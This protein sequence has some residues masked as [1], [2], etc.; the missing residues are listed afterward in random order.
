MIFQAAMPCSDRSKRRRDSQPAWASGCARI[1]NGAFCRRQ[2]AEEG[3]RGGQMGRNAPMGGHGLIRSR[4]TGGGTESDGCFP[5]FTPCRNAF[6]PAADSF[7]MEDPA[8]CSE[9]LPARSRA[10]RCR[11]GVRLRSPLPARRQPVGA[12]SRARMP[13]CPRERG[14]RRT[15]GTAQIPSRDRGQ[16]RQRNAHAGHRAGGSSLTPRR[17]HPEQNFR[18]PH[19]GSF[20]DNA[21]ATDKKRGVP[22][23]CVGA[24]LPVRRRPKAGGSG[25][26]ELFFLCRHGGGEA[27]TQRLERIAAFSLSA[28][29]RHTAWQ[30]RTAFQSPFLCPSGGARMSPVI[31]PH[32]PPRHLPAT[33]RSK[34]RGG[35]RRPSLRTH[36]LQAGEAEPRSGLLP[37]L[38]AV[39]A[40]LP[41]GRGS[42][43][44]RHSPGSAA[45]ER[46][47]AL[48]SKRSEAFY[49]RRIEAQGGEKGKSARRRSF[50]TFLILRRNQSFFCSSSCCFF[51]SSSRRARRSTLPTMDLG[52]SSRNSKMRGTL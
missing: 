26:C 43:R 41:G 16:T 1:G 2:A 40:S 28:R 29:K 33:A 13:A 51:S 36:V 11:E 25:L 37:R 14:P 22:S 49:S 4:R 52:S 45:E 27:I 15:R 10:F 17:K 18:E 24:S 44:G 5:L 9:A 19:R 31:S 48:L 32:I 12:R 38:R 6:L 3:R 23:A 8:S 46:R 20:S 35:A 21:E 34:Q 47:A 39:K 42:F 7:A 30:E 50:H